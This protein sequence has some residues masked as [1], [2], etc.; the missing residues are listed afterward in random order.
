MDTSAAGPFF[1]LQEKTLSEPWRPLRDLFN[2][3]VLEESVSAVSGFLERMAGTTIQPRVAAST[4]SLAL[5]A[6]LVAPSLGASV[7]RRQVPRLSLDSSY[8]IAAI[9]GPWPLALTDPDDQPDPDRELREVVLPLAEIIS[10]QF[11]LSMRVLHGNAASGVFGSVR[12]LSA[13][14]P[15]LAARGWAVGRSLL[16]GAL[17]GTGSIIRT[18]SGP[19]FVRSSCCLYYRIPGAG[20][21]GDCILA[22][23]PAG[24]RRSS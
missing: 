21:C 7:L 6:R 2:A 14:R 13:A 23:R 16:T 20:N 11:S 4:M 8:W 10:E 18:A 9:G 12:V 19:E 3:P 24:T 22:H 1:A 15:D 17:D 5:F